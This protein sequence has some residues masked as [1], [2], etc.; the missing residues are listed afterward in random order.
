VKMFQN[1]PKPILRISI[2][3]AGHPSCGPLVLPGYPW[4]IV[5]RRKI[6]S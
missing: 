4:V 5:A 6:P 2:F 1:P 3:P